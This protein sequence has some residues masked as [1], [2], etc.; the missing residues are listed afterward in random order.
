MWSLFK[1]LRKGGDEFETFLQA[2]S[3]DFTHLIRCR[4]YFGNRQVLPRPGLAWWE[5]SVDLTF[6]NFAT[7]IC[8]TRLAVKAI[9][10][11]VDE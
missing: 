11:R 5:G 7:E 4:P 3:W 9:G 8:K 6:S 2:Q 1:D 10:H